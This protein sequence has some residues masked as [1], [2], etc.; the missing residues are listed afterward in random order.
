M[1]SLDI[2][3]INNDESFN[4]NIII[5]D[6]LLSRDYSRI[7]KHGFSIFD[8]EIFPIQI[9]YDMIEFIELYFYCLETFSKVRKLK[10]KEKRRKRKQRDEENEEKDLLKLKKETKKEN[11]LE[12]KKI[13][14]EYEINNY[15]SQSSISYSSDDYEFKERDVDLKNEIMIILDYDVIS[16]ILHALLEYKTIKSINLIRILAKLLNRVIELEGTWIFYNIENLNIFHMLINDHEFINNL[17]YRELYESINK[18]LKI[19]FDLFKVNKLL[20][21]ESLFR[22]N[23]AVQKDEIINNYELKEQNDNYLYVRQDLE[24]EKERIYGEDEQYE[25]NNLFFS[26]KIKKNK[27]IE[28]VKWNLNEDIILIENYLKFKE[29]DNFMDILE[30]LFM[31]K[32]RKDIKKRIKKLKLK[33]GETKAMKRLNKIHKNFDEKSENYSNNKVIIL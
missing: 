31:N 3:K 6:S 7:I 13:D 22:F 2:H 24:L 21:I 10:I 17:F 26:N 19:Y 11:Y 30:G 14:H 15:N 4:I 8:H 28:S 23:S 9:L 33:K 1:I 16:K 5:Q 29:I 32:K 25:G 18:I 27:D 20:L 12:N